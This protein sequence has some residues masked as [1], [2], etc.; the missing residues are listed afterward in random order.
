MREFEIG[1]GQ[2]TSSDI[3]GAFSANCLNCDSLE[4]AIV[5]L[6]REVHGDVCS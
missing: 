3:N 5:K 6:E 2:H 4:F 1:I